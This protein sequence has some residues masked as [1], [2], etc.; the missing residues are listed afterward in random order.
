M[1]TVSESVTHL[2]RNPRKYGTFDLIYAGGLYDYLSDVFARRLT[3]S[4]LTALRPG[5]RLL[6]GNFAPGLVET[7]FMEAFMDWFLIYRTTAQVQAIADGLTGDVAD[8]EIVADD[9]GQVVYL[10]LTKVVES[11]PASAGLAATASVA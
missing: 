9:D 10:M 4:L 1:E 8:C 7:G 6:I 11:A 2:L 5:G 3:D